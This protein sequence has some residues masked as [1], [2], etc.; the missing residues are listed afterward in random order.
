MKTV[1]YKVR[2]L[3]KRPPKR[4]KELEAVWRKRMEMWLKTWSEHIDRLYGVPEKHL[5]VKGKC[6]SYLAM[7]EEGK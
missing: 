1:I 5:K 6:P 2:Y 4:D 7:R 3:G